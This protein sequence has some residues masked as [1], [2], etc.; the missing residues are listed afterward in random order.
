MKTLHRKWKKI[1][2]INK[3]KW[4][5]ERDSMFW[6]MRTAAVAAVTAAVAA[7]AVAQPEVECD[8][9]HGQYDGQEKDALQIHRGKGF[10][11]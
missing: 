10:R 3:N 8:G 2:K 7:T 6:M 4:K 9:C 5:P 11:G 1:C